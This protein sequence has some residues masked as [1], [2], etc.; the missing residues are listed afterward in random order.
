MADGEKSLSSSLK[1]IFEQLKY[2][3]NE[4]KL[5]NAILDSGINGL[6]DFREEIAPKIFKSLESSVT[7][8]L[9]TV[10]S[11]EI[12]NKCA[13]NANHDIRNSLKS[14]FVLNKF[15]DGNDKLLNSVCKNGINALYQMR[16]D[17]APRVYNSLELS[18]KELLE[19]N[20]CCIA[21]DNEEKTFSESLKSV[22]EL[23][24][25]NDTN[26][27]LLNA[28]LEEG[29]KG[30]YKLKDEIPPKIFKKL[31]SSVEEL[32]PSNT[33]F[34]Y[35]QDSNIQVSFKKFIVNQ[36]RVMNVPNNLHLHL[37]EQINEILSNI[38]KSYAF[39]IED[40]SIYDMI[41]NSLSLTDIEDVKNIRTFLEKLWKPVQINEELKLSLLNKVILSC[42]EVVKNFEGNTPIEML[43]RLKSLINDM[44][45]DRDLFKKDCGIYS[46]T[47]TSINSKQRHEEFSDKIINKLKKQKE[48]LMLMP[49]CLEKSVLNLI[50]LIRLKDLPDNN[51][52]H[53]L[54]KEEEPI[55][56]D[57]HIFSL[58]ERFA[59]EGLNF[60]HET[61]ENFKTAINLTKKGCFNSALQGFESL[62]KKIQ[63]LDIT[64]ITHLLE[65]ANENY[66][67]IE[68][69]DIILLLGMTGSGKTATI[70][71]LSGSKMVEQKVEIKPGEFLNHITAAE[72]FP[73]VLSKF[74][75]S[76]RAES[77]TRYINPIQINLKDLGAYADKFII[78]CDSPGFGDTAGPEVDIANSVSIVEGIS[79][80]KSVRPVILMNYENQGGRG[81]GI[82]A[83]TRMIQDMVINIEEYLS[84][85]SY[86]FT[87]YPEIN[88]YTSL[89]NIYT[90]IEKS[91]SEPNDETFKAIFEDMLKKTKKNGKSLDLIKNNPLDVLSKIINTHCIDD[92]KRVFRYTMAE[93]SKSA[94]Y[95]QSE[96]N[97]SAIIC[98]AKTNNYNLIKYKIGELIFLSDTLKLNEVKQI[99]KESIDFVNTHIERRY[100]D[101]KERLNRCLDNQSKLSSDELEYYVSHIEKF[102]ELHIF[103]DV[104]PLIKVSN[105]SEAL[106]QNLRL[107]CDQELKAFKS[108]DIFDNEY[109]KTSLHNL[110]IMT[111]KCDNQ[112]YIYACQFVIDQVYMIQASL[113]SFLENNDFN[114]SANVLQRSKIICIKLE[115]HENLKMQ[116]TSVYEKLKMLVVSKLKKLSE[117][118]EHSLAQQ[119]LTDEDLS[120]INDCLQVLENAKHINLLCE[121]IT[122]EEINKHC[123]T[124]LGK[125]LQFYENLNNKI[126]YLFKNEK[127]KE[128][129]AVCKQM[130]LVRRI[131]SVEQ[132]TAEAYYS[133]NQS[134]T[135][136]MKSLSDDTEKLLNNNNNSN[137]VVDYNKI[138]SNLKNLIDAEWLNHKSGYYESIIKNIQNN[139]TDRAFIL[140]ETLVETNLDLESYSELEKVNKILQQ[141]NGLKKFQNI[142]PEIQKH[143]DQSSEYFNNSVAKSFEDIKNTFCL[144]KQSVNHLKNRKAKLITIKNEYQ[145][146]QPNILYLKSEQFTS[147]EKVD[148]KIME[149]TNSINETEKN[150]ELCKSKQDQFTSVLNEYS[151]SLKEPKRKK[152][153]KVL[154]SHNFKSVE[155]IFNKEKENENKISELKSI[156][157]KSMHQIEH[158]ETVKLKFNEISSQNL[159]SNEANEYISKTKYKNIENLNNRINELE[160]KIDDAELNG[161]EF[162]FKRLDCSKAEAALNYLNSCISIKFI[163]NKTT[164][165]KLESEIFLNKYKMFITF[166]TNSCLNKIQTLNLAN[167]FLAHGLTQRI[168]FRLEECNEIQN[169]TLLNRLMQSQHIKKD[170]VDRLSN[171]HLILDQPNINE[172]LKTEIVKA[173]IQLDKY[174]ENV[175]FCQ[176]YSDYNQNRIKAFNDFEKNIME[177]MENYKFNEVAM[178]LFGV[179]EK[180]LSCNTIYK[181]K[182]SLANSVKKIITKTKYHLRALGNSLDKNEVKKIHKQLLRLDS[183]KINLYS[184]LELEEK[185]KLN[186][187]I[188]QNTDKELNNCLKFVHET[189]CKKILKFIDKIMFHINNNSFYEAEVEREHLYDIHNLLENYCDSVEI[190]NS[191]EA[192]QENLEDRINA[193]TEKFVK[194]SVNDYYQNQPKSVLDEL[195]KLIKH[196][197][198]EKYV[199]LSS[200]IKK[201]IK[202]QMEYVF[203]S[204]KNAKPDE[205]AERIDFIKAT[206][207]SLPDCIKPWVESE[208][209]KIKNQIDQENKIYQD[210]FNRIKNASDVKLV[211]KFMEKC[212]DNGMEEYIR[213]IQ[214][215]VIDQV[216]EC[217]RDLTKYFDENDISKALKMFN[218]YLEF[219]Q[220]FGE[221]FIDINSIFSTIE[222]NLSNKFNSICS[223]FFYISCN[224]DIEF[225]LKNF[226]NLNYFIDLKKL[227]HQSFPRL[228]NLNRLIDHILSG[229][230]KSYESIADFFLDNQKKFQSSLEELSISKI[231]DS[232]TVCQKWSFLLDAIN[233]SKTNTE[234][235][236][237]RNIMSKIE[238][239]NCYNEMTETL[240]VKLKTYKLQIFK[241]EILKAYNNERDLFYQEFVKHISFLC[242]SKELKNHIIYD[243][244]NPNSYENE[245]FPFLTDFFNKL[246]ESTKNIFSE[247]TSEKTLREFDL[248]RLNLENIKSFDMHSKLVGLNFKFSTI[249][250]E[251]NVKL[252]STLD[253]H[254]K[255]AERSES[256]VYEKAQWLIKIK[257]FANNLPECSKRINE[258]LDKVFKIYKNSHANYCKIEIAKLGIALEQDPS[259]VGFNIIAEHAVFKGQIISIFNQSTK[260]HGIDYVLNKL[261]GDNI[262]DESMQRLK[263]VYNLYLKSYQQTVKK[264]I[265]KIKEKGVLN[266]LVRFIKNNGDQMAENMF[267]KNIW[268][269][270]DR[271]KMSILVASIFALW[272]LQNAEYYNEMEGIE[273]QDSYLLTPHPS[274]VISIFRML[275]F[276]YMEI[277]QVKGI[278]DTF[279]SVVSNEKLYVS[280]DK[281]Q[282][283]LVQVG[284]G[285]GKSLILAVVSC[286]LSLI[287]FDVS[288]ACYSEYLSSRDYKS[289]LPLFSS[290]GLTS[291]IRY[292]TFNTV[293]EDVINQNCNIRNRVADLV[294]NKLTETILTHKKPT[295]PM[296]LLIDEVDVFFNKDFY[297]NLYTPLARIKNPCIA[298]LT[299]YIWSHR[300]E[301]LTL[302]HLQSS[303]EYQACCNYFKDWDFLVTEAVKDMLTDVQDFKHDYIIKNDKL[304]YK[305]Q[306]GISYDIVYGYKTLF[307]YCF[308]HDEGQISSESLEEVIS[309]GIKCGSFSFAEIPNNFHYITG[310]SGTLKTLSSSEKK[311]VKSYGIEKFTYIPSIFGENK[312][313][314]AKEAD[315][316]LEN[317]DDYFAKLNEHIEYSSKTQKEYRRPVLVF[318]TTKTSLME[319]YDSN[320]LTLN[321]ENIQIITEEVSES[322]K[323]KEMLIK[324]ATISGQIT[325]LTRA[326]GRGTDFI[327]SDQNVI[328]NGGVH[329]IQTFFSEELSEEVQ[330][331]GRT[332]RQGKD[333]SCSMVLRDSDLEKY[334]GVDYSNII[335]KL[336]NEKVIYE[337]LNLKRNMFFDSTYLNINAQVNAAKTEHLLA[338]EFVKNLNNNEIDKIKA[339]LSERNIGSTNSVISSRTVCLMDA[340]GSMSNLLNKAKITVG[341]MFER[342]SAILTENSIPADSFQMQFA[343]YRDYDC[344]N[345]GLLQY[346]PWETKPENLRLFMDKISAHG[347]GDYE[348][349]I[350]IGLWH[351]NRENEENTVNQVILIGDAPAKTKAQIN[352]YRKVKGESYWQKTDFKVPTFYKDEVEKLKKSETV[353]HTFYLVNGAKSNFQEISTETGGICEPLN[354]DSSDGANVLTDI[355]TRRILGNVGQLRGKGNELVNAYNERYTK[356]YK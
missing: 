213:L 271:K 262:N 42:L 211:Y 167:S 16:D 267:E 72:P 238:S 260:Y 85:F 31:E 302:K 345:D 137:G 346:S 128:M 251:I 178:K 226:R 198:N 321:K 331:Q 60:N 166:E 155:D 276:G 49:N 304:A 318:F 201:A 208:R 64:E 116:I 342:A 200:K 234:N 160:N 326:F 23:S 297:G 157:E 45:H 203:V 117:S 256:D 296:I 295:R 308:E 20:S 94:V 352:D 293:C 228:T 246:S 225:T 193:I 65:K 309:I 194:M 4:D 14:I 28:I 348:E 108:L 48:R 86:L 100:E 104:E 197:S 113:E 153:K 239:C 172:S 141:L 51:I 320:K 135:A 221:T 127:F 129:E 38:V 351:V 355:V 220:V 110:K 242:H 210:D 313:R 265:M 33:K 177:F 196:T 7:D 272:T 161:I 185:F 162:L 186:S 286:V 243:I 55:D 133:T 101:T 61:K 79:R 6:N 2:I 231:N 115:G 145:L 349:A 44:P 254:F 139:L 163:N 10:N 12:E 280:N 218:R 34:N 156:I 299:R 121:H 180:V 292:A 125:I 255:M 73:D 179:D 307:A 278:I 173:F 269:E 182:T 43:E 77:E 356:S 288:C 240:S 249:V 41:N 120:A 282:N 123:E 328:A 250:E 294:S 175:K 19:S 217:N 52:T 87:K 195:D 266:E 340:T 241:I 324:R 168:K 204:I 190:S 223:N 263:Y 205:R 237:V 9:T 253:Y 105:L 97:K 75:I 106:V 322:P 124:F 247:D 40:Q 118:C 1:S 15:V 83:M 317:N 319:F 88:I 252:E 154:H 67:L 89:L 39:C 192:I 82:R 70:H 335:C 259:G 91:M 132:R 183:A 236:F 245:I 99:L 130:Q 298:D 37:Q 21:N 171:Y 176:L 148:E 287:G 261:E 30:L 46:G 230:S 90:S 233:N 169:Y 144:D 92:P 285:E 303:P 224:S 35:N 189:I 214:N 146:M 170:I 136:Y 54:K 327:C 107:R 222:C 62:L 98:A 354:I 235:F 219:I 152:S 334:L 188:D 22:I 11:L 76:C 323:E 174:A 149:L 289:F 206:L 350:E 215:I 26:G 337:T 187:Y 339:F 338:E 122:K 212:K 291:H 184:N 71:F 274:Q 353:V 275:G 84:T 316:F 191:I 216:E 102:K 63:P 58:N 17:I 165:I 151:A 333:G 159:T 257:T 325:F 270:N 164:S 290:L 81:E 56:F 24:E 258:K 300:K 284:T 13:A 244:F 103:K 301:K 53:L 47:E 311:I 69:Q 59:I 279:K 50:Y 134:I 93:Q 142:I 66:N 181:I 131:G 329:V 306:D 5:L 232:M 341:T 80:C 96:Y 126:N 18:I 343:V 112:G 207:Y 74:V 227:K 202:I 158:L 140:F 3:D 344:L 281:L 310:V 29:I 109:S 264:Y 25:F 119:Y 27:V 332:A 150:M 8:L 209:E 36:L 277:K 199:E 268:D 315:I 314:F 248:F 78:L 273:N 111:E 330:I 312:R 347:G 147:I 143:C 57:I 68:N 229:L 114:R 95:M 138:Y 283:N 32:L 336:R 305:E